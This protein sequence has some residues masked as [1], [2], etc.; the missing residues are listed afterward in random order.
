MF[1]RWCELLP[2][3]QTLVRASA[4][5]SSARRLAM[6]CTSERALF[7][8]K[9]VPLLDALAMEGDEQVFVWFQVPARYRMDLKVESPHE[10]WHRLLHTAM[11]NG[12]WTTTLCLM[13]LLGVSTNASA[14]C[15]DVC[16]EHGQWVLLEFL[17]RDHTERA[18]FATRRGGA[19]LPLFKQPH[20]AERYPAYCSRMG[21]PISDVYERWRTALAAHDVTG[22]GW[23]IRKLGYR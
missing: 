16:I 17:A 2:E 12:R 15:L 14:C 22:M 6:T 3:L 21:Y 13:L 9:R 1:V 7:D 8:G 20:L 10:R 11:A 5:D 4:C 23:V 19:Y 18:R